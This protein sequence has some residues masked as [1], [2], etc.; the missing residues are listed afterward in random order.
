MSPLRSLFA[1]AA[2]AYPFLLPNTSLAA[3]HSWCQTGDALSKTGGDS[4]A[5]GVVQWVC[6][7][8]DGTCC[9]D[10]NG[11]LRWSMDCVQWAADYAKDPANTTLG[12]YCGRYAWAQ[13]PLPNTQQAFPRDF[14]LVALSGDVNGALDIADPIAAK[15]NVTAN[16]FGLNN[17]AREPYAIVAGGNVTL[18]SGTVYGH[19]R[20]SLDYSEACPS[21]GGTVTYLPP[22]TFTHEKTSTL[23]VDFANW[24]GPLT[25]MSANLKA[26]Y[27]PGAVTPAGC[28]LYFSGLDNDM[29]VFQVDASKF[30]KTCSYKFLVPSTSAAIVNIIPVKN[31]DGSFN[32]VTIS[33][34]AVQGVEPGNLLWNLV[35]KAPIEVTAMDFYG[36]ILAPYSQVKL[37]NSKF[38]GS[39]VAASISLSNAE[40]HTAPYHVPATQLALAKQYI[41]HVVVIMQENRSFDNYFGTFPK[42]KGIPSTVLGKTYDCD[43]NCNCSLNANGAG[44][45]KFARNP[46]PEAKTDLPHGNSDFQKSIANPVDNG[47]TLSPADFLHAACQYIGGNSNTTAL[48]DVLGYHVGNSSS[49]ELYNYWQYAKNFLLQDNMFESVPDWSPIE[50]N[51]MVSAWNADCASG[52]CKTSLTYNANGT[53]LWNDISNLLCGG[54]VRWMFYQ[55]EDWIHDCKSCASPND[56]P[57]NCFNTGSDPIVAFWSPLGRFQTYQ[58]NKSN[59]NNTGDIA[60][61]QSF[62]TSLNNVGTSADQDGSK[63]PAVSWIVPG[64]QVSEHTEVPGT[65]DT[66]NIKWGEGYVTSIVNAVMSNR[67]LWET[68]AIFLSWDDWG[69]FYDHMPPVSNGTSDAK[70]YQTYGIRVPG[71]VISPWVKS[72]GYI[73]SNQLSH[74]AYLKFIEDVFL[75]G[76]RI[77]AGQGNGCYTVSTSKDPRTEARETLSAAG[78]LKAD[79]D[80]SHGPLPPLI[81]LQCAY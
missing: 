9:T 31:S 7:N 44:K 55:G 79:F 2:L 49:D 22:N 54:G 41:K 50:H 20:L 1:A 34:S 58:Q 33:N 73:D 56:I 77:L 61:L 68:T 52:T 48:Q 12:D 23:P 29:N 6:Q 60:E 5:N 76:K 11:T 53:Y 4:K 21:G 10:G 8:K 39:V 27:S 65:I 32:T 40:L 74:D 37:S 51:Y 63:F 16:A 36:S 71:L 47:A 72:K 45:Y 70:N 35:D 81:G 14:S 66:M 69:G 19:V 59:P 30:N 57:A 75:G 46:D 78:D 38:T 42:A 3:Y 28:V 18:C 17:Q 62:Y 13:G 67:T 24:T 80:F 26:N 64:R 43:S 15:G 25:T